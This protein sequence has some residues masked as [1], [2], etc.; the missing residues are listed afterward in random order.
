MTK[1][2]FLVKIESSEINLNMINPIIKIYGN[3]K[4]E[5][6]KKMLSIQKDTLFFDDYRVLAHDEI[7]NANTEL[8]VPFTKKKIIPLIDCGENDFIVYNVVKD[9]V[10]KFNI[11]DEAYFKERTSLTD[12]L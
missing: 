6:I 11:V 10:C 1:K 3:I 5:Q 8:H 2:Q 12:I 9:N 4:S 7:I